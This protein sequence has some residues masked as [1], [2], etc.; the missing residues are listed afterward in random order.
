MSIR[1]NG[2]LEID[3]QRGV[4]YFHL[5][6]PDEIEKYSTVTLLRLAGLSI[7]IPEGQLDINI[8]KEIKKQIKKEGFSGTYFEKCPNCDHTYISHLSLLKDPNN[9][10]EGTDK[11]ECPCRRIPP[12]YYIYDKDPAMI[13]D[14]LTLQ[15]FNIDYTDGP[16]NEEEFVRLVVSKLNS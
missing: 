16:M 7:P 3:S 4:I 13:K 10:C 1:F 5:S 11:C 12:R 9:K 15:H 8:R 14:A 2:Q 6:N